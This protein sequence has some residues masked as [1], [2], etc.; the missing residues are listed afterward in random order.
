LKIE[1]V[2]IKN[3]LREIEKQFRPRLARD[4]IKLTVAYSDDDG[5]VA[6]ADSAALRQVLINLIL[7]GAQACR[8][9]WSK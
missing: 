8:L 3:L 5:P 6:A 7:N 9:P 4:S 1:P 2:D